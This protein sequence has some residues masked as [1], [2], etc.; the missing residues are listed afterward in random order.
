MSLIYIPCTRLILS[1][2]HH[3]EINQFHFKTLHFL[4]IH[5]F[6][7]SKTEEATFKT[8]SKPKEAVHPNTQAIPFN[9]D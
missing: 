3:F 4:R 7:T 2:I 5:S 1:N 9:L 8:A 6:K